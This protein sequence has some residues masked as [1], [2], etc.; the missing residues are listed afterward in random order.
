M[1][2]GYISLPQIG[3]AGGGIDSINGDTSSAQSIV[4]GTGITVATS[5]G[6]TTIT[7]TGGGGGVSSVTATAPITS[8]GGTTPNIAITGHSLTEATSAVLT[9]TGGSLSQL[10]ATTIQVK[11]ASG[12]QAGYLSSADWTTFNGKQASGN[13]ITSLTGDVTAS[14][15]GSSVATLAAT[16]NATLT[17]LSALSLPTS[18][19]SGSI[20]LAS[21]V[22]GNL[23][24]THLNS[25]T[26]ASSSTFWRGDGTWATPGGASYTFA[27]SLVNTAGTV[28][29]V[30]DS[31]SPGASM[32][33]GTNSGST[34]GYYSLGAVSGANAALSNLSSVAIN[35]NLLWGSD[36]TYDIGGP[37]PTAAARPA[38]IWAKTAI[39]AG[40]VGDT[41]MYENTLHLGS[42]GASSAVTL[43]MSSQFEFQIGSVTYMNIE[44]NT[45][46]D[47]GTI[48][49][50]ATSGSGVTAGFLTAA[51]QTP[52]NTQAHN[53]VAIGCEQ[54]LSTG[55]SVLSAGNAAI[56][57][58]GVT[59]LLVTGATGI[60]TIGAASSTPQHVLN[61]AHTTGSSTGT[62]T[63]V[64]NSGGNPT[65]YIEITVN[66]TTAYIPYWT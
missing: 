13:Y 25:G 15:P 51:Y 38:H 63:N 57:A 44:S 40:S 56:C 8:S 19:L 1:S 62:L 58:T 4:G 11:Q 34:L 3:G 17:T 12:S 6:S 18:Q 45:T 22:S 23:S 33:Y 39:I 32:Y 24:T 7:A 46:S 5:S 61:T 47:F 31:A 65:G 43:T 20:N 60:T 29:L 35:T 37:Y 14:G 48:T 50:G 42:N 28:T 55:F 66:G 41:Y 26:S 10:V 21:Q 64:P 52:A 49:V 27:D 59:G 30:G 2:S 54:D 36:G 9:I 53:T 16:S